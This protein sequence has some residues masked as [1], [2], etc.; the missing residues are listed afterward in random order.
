MGF[1]NR[2]KK[3]SEAT[4]EAEEEVKAMQKRMQEALV[5]AKVAEYA[6]DAYIRSNR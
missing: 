3:S 5:Q 4:K 6:I 2:N 1:F